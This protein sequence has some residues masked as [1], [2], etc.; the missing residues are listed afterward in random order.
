M[1]VLQQ[2]NKNGFFLALFLGQ[3]EAVFIVYAFVRP[4]FA[5]DLF[6]ARPASVCSNCEV[7]R[8]NQVEKERLLYSSTLPVPL[9]VGHLL[10]GVQTLSSSPCLLAAPDHSG[11]VSHTPSITPFP[12][13]VG[14]VLLFFCDIGNLLLQFFE[15][16]GSNITSSS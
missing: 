6:M 12:M 14:Q 9:Q 13:Q 8:P 1:S 3:E 10:S 15:L 11:L 16:K 2:K 4:S 7:L 5:V